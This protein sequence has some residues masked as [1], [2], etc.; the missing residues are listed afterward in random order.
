LIFKKNVQM[1]LLINCPCNR[2]EKSTQVTNQPT[3]FFDFSFLTLMGVFW[4]HQNLFSQNFHFFHVPQGSK[5]PKENKMLLFCC[6]ML[7][8]FIKLLSKLNE[9]MQKKQLFSIFQNFH[10]YVKFYRNKDFK[11]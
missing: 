9:E 5:N 6:M 2:Y 1:Y 8:I 7:Y 11:F 4:F 3:F 10:F